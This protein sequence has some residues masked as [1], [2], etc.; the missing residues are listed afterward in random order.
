VLQFAPDGKLLKSWGGPGQGH[1][2]PKS[3]HGIHIGMDGNVWLAGNDKDDHQILKFTPDGKFLQQIGK[4]ASTGGSNSTTQLGRPAHM[5]TDDTAGEL[6]V[7][8]GYSNRRVIVFDSKTGAYKRHWGAY[9]IK[10]PSDDK[11]PPTSLWPSPSCRSRS[12]TRCIAS[13]CRAMVSFM[14]ATGSMTASRSLR[15]MA[16]L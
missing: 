6:Y 8:D 15:K 12:A 2:W 7:A 10:Q 1:D 13:G 5:V 11:L 14:C 3:E 4:A 9:G 16:R